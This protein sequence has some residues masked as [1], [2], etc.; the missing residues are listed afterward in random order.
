MGYI[1]KTGSMV[2]Q[3]REYNHVDSFKHGLAYVG[4]RTASTVISIEPGSR[5]G[6]LLDKRRIE[7]HFRSTI[8]DRR[9]LHCD[10]FVIR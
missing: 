9:A 6:S 2:I 3:A 1:D 10:P 4:P 5:C 7:E 8:A